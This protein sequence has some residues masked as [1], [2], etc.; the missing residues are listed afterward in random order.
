MPSSKIV[1]FLLLLAVLCLPS[2]AAIQWLPFGPY[3]GD[4]RALAADPHDSAHVY[5]GTVNGLIYESRDGGRRWER[6]ARIDGRDDFIVDAI[7]VDPANSR[8][9]LAGVYELSSPQGGLYISEDGGRTWI[10]QPDMAGQSIRAMAYAPSDSRTVVAGTLTGVYRSQD[11]GVHWQ[12]ISPEIH[13]IASVAIDPKDP[14]IIYAGTWHLPWK[15]TDGGEH[16][17]NIK[18]GVIEDS[19]V[20]SIIVDPEQPNVVYASA[21]S[22]IYKSENG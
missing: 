3:G 14:N 19:D 4:A 11:G 8:R 7:I 15:T 1:L 9:I 12:L 6:L 13:E 10:S 22:G 17:T 16:W 18:K 5:L 21:C 20:F 2:A